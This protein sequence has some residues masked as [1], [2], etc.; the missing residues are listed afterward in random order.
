MYQTHYSWVYLYERL[1]SEIDELVEE[2]WKEVPVKACLGPIREN[3]VVSHQT[4]YV[5]VVEPMVLQWGSVLQ[6]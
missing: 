6:N 2:A 4:R 5:K 1:H 3:Q